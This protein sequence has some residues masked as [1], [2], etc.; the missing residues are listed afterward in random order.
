M[1]SIS[2]G[3]EEFTGKRGMCFVLIPLYAESRGEK[4]EDGRF[5]RTIMTCATL[6][7]C[8]TAK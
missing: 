5:C 4:T 6:A 8:D 1:F 7:D 2:D 3:T